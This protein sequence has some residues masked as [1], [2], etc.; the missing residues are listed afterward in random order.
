[1]CFVLLAGVFGG[2]VG[3]AFGGRELLGKPDPG[4]LS[5]LE[6]AGALLRLQDDD[7]GSDRGEQLLALV[8]FGADCGAFGGQ[9][10]GGLSRCRDFLS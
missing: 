9:P 5:Q 10:G 8:Q 7:L 2:E 6:L 1:L 3:G 4:L